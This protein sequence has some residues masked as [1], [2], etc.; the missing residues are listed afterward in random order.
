MTLVPEPVLQ[1][2]VGWRRALHRIPGLA[3][4]VGDTADFVAERL[5]DLGVATYRG[6][7]GVGVVGVLERGAGLRIALRA[8]MDALP[9]DEVGR[10]DYGSRHPGVMHACGH[11]GHTAMLLGAAAALVGDPTFGGRVVFIFQP[12]E[13]PGLGA[14]AMIEDGLFERFAVDEVYGLHNAPGLPVG[15]FQTRTGPIE[16]SEHNLEIVVTG[17]GGHA[18][19][20]HVTDDT[21]LASCQIVTALQSIVSRRIDPAEPAVISITE[22]VTDGV[23]NALPGRCVLRGETRSYSTSVQHTLEAELTRMVKQVGAAF[24]VTASF[25][26]SQSF[27][28]TINAGPQTARACAAAGRVAGMT[29]EANCEPTMTSDDF[30][31]MLEVVPGNYAYLG[32]GRRGEAGGEPLHCARYDFNDA[33]LPFGVGYFVELARGAARV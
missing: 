2:A 15:A 7:G 20:A 18:A 16:A 5:A 1:A 33:A 17:I 12:A 14:R 32:N 27:S 26:I 31:A 10:G 28:P 23:R 24:G 4:D 13:E 19:R 21:L 25:E 11:D 8:D 6:I 3:F 22:F 9:I 29:I 30:G